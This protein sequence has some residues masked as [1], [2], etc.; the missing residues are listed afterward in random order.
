VRHGLASVEQAVRASGGEARGGLVVVTDGR[1]D[2]AGRRDDPGLLAGEA[3]RRIAR[4]AVDSSAQQLW[5]I[6][7]GNVDA[8]ELRALAGDKG[9]PYII[10]LSPTLL[11]QSLTSIAREV[12]TARELVFGL[13]SGSRLRLA[14]ARTAGALRFRATA[15]GGETFTRLLG[16]RPPLVALPAFQGV[17]DSASLPPEVRAV[18]DLG[19]SDTDRRWMLAVFFALAGL[20]LA[21]TLPRLL[22][23][24]PVAPPAAAAAPSSAGAEGAEGAAA[25]V[26]ASAAAPADGLRTDVQEVAP[27]K[28]DEITASFKRVT[29]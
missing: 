27:R 13:S 6:G 17:A 23:S 29:P 18:M 22:W 8:G 19:G 14:R 4:A 1:N 12:S 3:G 21:G 15:E 10:A 24:G 25:P 28:P 20:L 11:T 16:W 26:T 2:V 5:I 9:Q 7:A